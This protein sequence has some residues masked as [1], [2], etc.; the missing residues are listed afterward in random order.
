MIIW[1]DCCTG[2]C[3]CGK[4]ISCTCCDRLTGTGSRVKGTAQWEYFPSAT[5]RSVNTASSNRP[6]CNSC[7][8]QLLRLSKVGWLT[9]L[10]Q[11]WASRKE[12]IVMSLSVGL[13]LSVCL[14]ASISQNRTSYFLNQI[15][16][17]ACGRGSV[18]LW[19]H[20]G[21]NEGMCSCA[22][23]LQQRRCGVM[24]RLTPLLLGAGCVLS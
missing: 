24:R 18:I 15:M 4:E 3:R 20:N 7:S 14:F 21:P 1:W 6:T 5:S 12:S 17:I 13:C 2:N 23:R 9:N 19:R 11:H 10:P 22:Q 16:R 8:V